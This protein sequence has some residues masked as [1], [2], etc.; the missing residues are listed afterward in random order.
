MAPHQCACLNRSPSTVEVAIGTPIS[1]WIPADRVYVDNHLD[2]AVVKVLP[3]LLPGN[4]TAAKLGCT[5]I[6]KQG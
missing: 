3:D 1:D 5:Q 4:A 2:I 6:V